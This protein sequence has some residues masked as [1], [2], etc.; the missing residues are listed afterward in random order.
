LLKKGEEKF[1]A[2]YSFAILGGDYY[3]NAKEYEKAGLKYEQ[4]YSIHPGKELA[5]VLF[6]LY[7][8]RNNVE[9]ANYFKAQYETFKS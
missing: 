9:K 3:Y 1:P 5:L 2:D 4:A 8:E 7:S 6:K